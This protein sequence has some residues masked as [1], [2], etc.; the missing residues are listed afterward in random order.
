MQF[1]D[2]RK[3]LLY[4][5]MFFVRAILQLYTYP[6]WDIYCEVTSTDTNITAK[7]NRFQVISSYTEHFS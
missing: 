7:V 2:N 3:A 1:V 5:N 6:K 4:N